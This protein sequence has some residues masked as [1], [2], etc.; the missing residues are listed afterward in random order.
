MVGGERELGREELSRAERGLGTLG[1][2]AMRIG[3][4]GEGERGEEGA[5]G[6]GR[7]CS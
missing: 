2:T 3:R 5:T 1:G 7:L 6:L 4:R